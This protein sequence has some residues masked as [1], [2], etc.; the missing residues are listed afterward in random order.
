MNSTEMMERF[1]QFASAD[2]SLT[3][4]NR[5]NL[6][7]EVLLTTSTVR[8]ILTRDK[9]K[10]ESLDVDIEVSLPFLPVTSDVVSMRGYIDGVIAILEYL[11]RL[12]FIGF[13]LEMLQEEGMLI[14]STTLSM[15]TEEHVFKVLKPP[16]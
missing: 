2:L 10:T 9:Y 15:E 5:M 16:D 14:A 12:T 13:G 1:R 8:I 3:T 4:P 6:V 7:S 11:K